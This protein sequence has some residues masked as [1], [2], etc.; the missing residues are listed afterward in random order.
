MTAIFLEIPVSSLL[1]IPEHFAEDLIRQLT[2]ALAGLG[3]GND[4]TVHLIDDLFGRPLLLHCI[5]V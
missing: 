3:G 1:V 4:D 5:A 2:G